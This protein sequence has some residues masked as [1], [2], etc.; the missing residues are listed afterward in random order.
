MLKWGW[1]CKPEIFASQLTEVATRL[2]KIKH[3][4]DIPSRKNQ[5]CKDCFQI[6]KIESHVIKFSQV[7]YV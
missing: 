6:V 5:I 7:M 2:H 3:L 4:I 1:D